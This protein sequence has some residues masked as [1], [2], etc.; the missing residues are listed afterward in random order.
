MQ[1]RR[2][3]I[4]SMLKKTSKKQVK[5]KCREVPPF[6]PL[7]VASVSNVASELVSY[8]ANKLSTLKHFA[9]EYCTSVEKL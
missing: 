1:F 9:K 4:A 6:N 2:R 5:N 7:P 8:T 3:K